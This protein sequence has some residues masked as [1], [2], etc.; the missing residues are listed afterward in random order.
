MKPFAYYKA[1]AKD[2]FKALDWRLQ[3]MLG[4]MALVAAGM[5]FRA[6]FSLFAG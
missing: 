4:C 1:A 5:F 3:L 6:L 2:W